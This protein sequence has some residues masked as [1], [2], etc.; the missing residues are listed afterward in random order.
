MRQVRVYTSEGRL[1][2]YI[3][4]SLPPLAAVVFFLLNPDYMMQLFI[5]PRGHK[6]IFGAITMQVIGYLVIRKIVKL[7][8]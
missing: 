2:L 8:V 3:L 4:T 7:K 6:M 5:D 1:S